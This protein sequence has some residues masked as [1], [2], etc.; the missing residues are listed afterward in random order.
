MKMSKNGE[1]FKNNKK[2]GILYLIKKI[3]MKNFL[4]FF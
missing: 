3:F 2:I 1:R 4:L